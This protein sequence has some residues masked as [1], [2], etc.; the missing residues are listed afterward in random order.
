[1]S[2]ARYVS[3]SD[4]PVDTVLPASATSTPDMGR[5]RLACESESV[6]ARVFAKV[7][8]AAYEGRRALLARA[9]GLA[10]YVASRA[11]SG[12]A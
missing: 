6:G 9:A 4:V 10:R 12:V 7:R 1:M 2:G 8:R 3:L 11:T 5:Q